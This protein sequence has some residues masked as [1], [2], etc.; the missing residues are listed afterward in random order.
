[1]L[2]VFV[3][4]ISLPHSNIHTSIDSGG[5]WQRTP[6]PS[7]VGPTL[8]KGTLNINGQPKDTFL[9]MEVSSCLPSS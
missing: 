2:D 8:F 4:C 5:M 7:Q 1:M 6:A 3:L 9:D